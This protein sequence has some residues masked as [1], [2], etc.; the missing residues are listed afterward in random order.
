MK[1]E[2]ADTNDEFIHA[3]TLQIEDR[4]NI[5]MREELE[6]LDLESLEG[7]PIGDG[8]VLYTMDWVSNKRLMAISEEG[9][10]LVYST[11]RRNWVLTQ[12][13]PSILDYRIYSVVPNRGFHC[14]DRA[15]QSKFYLLKPESVQMT[16]FSLKVSHAIVHDSSKYFCLFSFNM[17]TQKRSVMVYKVSSKRILR[18]YEH[19]AFETNEM[20]YESRYHGSTIIFS[21]AL[22]TIAIDTKANSTTVFKTPSHYLTDKILHVSF[23]DGSVQMILDNAEEGLKR[24]TLTSEGIEKKSLHGEKL[25]LVDS[26][27]SF[28]IPFGKVS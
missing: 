21:N 12:R 20:L 6:E 3:E 24:V 27:F 25:K 4:Q 26:D 9:E 16:G 15:D 22:Y 2:I 13:L 28:I 11:A 17:N 7:M 14:F 5:R 19:A 18:R 8:E 23:K 10:V 1:N